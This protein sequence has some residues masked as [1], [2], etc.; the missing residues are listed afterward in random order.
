MFPSCEIRWFLKGEIPDDIL[1]WFQSI[2]INYQEQTHRIDHYLK[3]PNEN[4]LGIKL[5]EG[6]VEIKKLKGS[7]KFLK[8]N[9][10]VE[11]YMESWEKWSFELKDS[12]SLPISDTGIKEW[13]AVK[14]KRQM[15]LFEVEDGKCFVRNQQSGQ[16]KNGCI[17]ELTTLSVDGSNFWTLGLEA[18]GETNEMWGNLN[19]VGSSIFDRKFCPTLLIDDSK[20][21][22][23]WISAL[24]DQ[25][26]EI[27]KK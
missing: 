26:S 18:F 27:I 14:K 13:I 16:L 1:S 21:Y 12:N 4:T 7:L 20:S 8:V 3:L 5:R 6:R 10:N 15:F 19:I 9:E 23:G 24:F 22:P 25:A 17:V 11:G 2:D